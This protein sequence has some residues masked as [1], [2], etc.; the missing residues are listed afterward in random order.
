MAAVVVVASKI[1]REDPI[2][3]EIF[4]AA[5]RY[6]NPELIVCLARYFDLHSADFANRDP[7]KHFIVAACA[8][9]SDQVLRLFLDVGPATGYAIFKLDEISREVVHRAFLSALQAYHPKRTLG[10]RKTFQITTAEFVIWLGEHRYENPKTKMSH[11]RSA[12]TYDWIWLFRAAGIDS[13]AVVHESPGTG[14]NFWNQTINAGALA[15]GRAFELLRMDPDEYD[16]DAK[17]MRKIENPN[18]YLRVGFLICQAA[19]WAKKV[20]GSDKSS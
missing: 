17:V 5:C 13:L 11:R 8:N 1:A 14:G 3:F 6:G 15:C 10:L 7:A 18:L 19:N 2:V 20:H 12:E 4:Y 16:T 9:P